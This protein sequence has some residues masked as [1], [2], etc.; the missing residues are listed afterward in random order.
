MFYP[1]TLSRL[2]PI[3]TMR[4]NEGS[5]GIVITHLDVKVVNLGPGTSQTAIIQIKPEALDSARISCEP[6]WEEVAAPKALTYGYPLLPNLCHRNP[7][8][9]LASSSRRQSSGSTTFVFFSHDTPVHYSTVS[10]TNDQCFLGVLRTGTPLERH[11][12]SN[13]IFP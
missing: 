12:S 11:G 7:Y 8:G 9:S 6:P 1:R 13:P 5:G 4:A 3:V 10:F 2:K